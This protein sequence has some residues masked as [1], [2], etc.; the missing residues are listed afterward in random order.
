[1]DRFE[2]NGKVAL[3]TGG[4]R[5]IGFETA[6]AL[7]EK[8]ASV[9]IVDLDAGDAELAAEESAPARSESAP[10]SPISKRCSVL[11]SKPWSSSAAST[12]SSRTPASG[13]R[14]TR[15]AGRTRR[16]STA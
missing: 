14:W 11:S 12:W 2:V 1:M 5:G 10:T 15:S 8:G 3:V 6:R 9:V 16:C 7:H 13:H 4:A